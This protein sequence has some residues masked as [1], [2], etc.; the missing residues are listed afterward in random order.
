MN[1]TPLQVKTCYSLLKSLNNIK[2]LVSYAASLGYKALAITDEN[3]MFGVPEFYQECKN[4]NIKPIIGIELDIEDKKILLYAMNNQGYKN[5]VKLSTIITTKSLTKED[6]VAHKD[7][8]LLIMPYKYF[9]QEIYDI[10]TNRYIGYTTKEEAQAIKEDKVF[11][12]N[13][14]YLSKNDYKYLDYA[15]M[16][17]ELK[18]LG[19]YELNTH[20]NQHLPTPEE[21]STLTTTLF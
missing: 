6:L 5:L 9:N 15:Y 20:Q 11:I 13:V 14:S 8:L 18:V 21:L 12:N 17:K 19:E 16:I 1:Y 4:N 7:N 10:Y 2:Q 3:N